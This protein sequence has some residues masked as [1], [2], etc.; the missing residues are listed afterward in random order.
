[1][2]INHIISVLEM[3]KKI[4]LLELESLGDSPSGSY[5]Y[6]VIL[7]INNFSYCATNG[8]QLK[9]I[10]M[11]SLEPILEERVESIFLNDFVKVIQL[12]IEQLYEQ[13]AKFVF[14][15]IKNEIFPC[16]FSEKWLDEELIELGLSTLDD[17]FNDIEP[18]MKQANK[19]IRFCFEQFFAAYFEFYL[20]GGVFA[21]D[22]KADHILLPPIAIEEGFDTSYSSM[23]TFVKRMK[24]DQRIILE[25]CEEHSSKIGQS[26]INK[27]VY[28]LETLIGF[29][30][31][32][33]I[34][35]EAHFD[36]L[37]K[38]F[39]NRE[40]VVMQIIL[41]QRADVKEEYRKRLL[42]ALEK[43]LN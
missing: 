29:Y 3:E 20:S 15:E 25:K 30:E 36:K 21:F 12:W 1:M 7:F 2:T 40:F 24:E 17:Y 9:K 23:K 43:F 26:T 42:D 4:L 13:L 11:A 27:F 37:T 14:V 38:H 34:D 22:L 18:L 32:S 39:E 10:S 5:M 28:S 41:Y 33:R 16:L 6:K 8:I 19:F 35:I 31:M